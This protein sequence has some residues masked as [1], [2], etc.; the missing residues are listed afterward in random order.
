MVAMAP[1][2]EHV[3]CHVHG[4]SGA[5][6]FQDHLARGAARPSS[7]WRS[8]IRDAVIPLTVASA[9]TWIS[10]GDDLSRRERAHRRI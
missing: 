8:Q 6:S 7:L 4:V 10:I 5:A 2:L 9:P 3:A 1:C